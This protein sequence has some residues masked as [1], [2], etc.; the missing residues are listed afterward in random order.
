MTENGNGNGQGS[1]NPRTIFNWL[2]GLFIPLWE[3]VDLESGEQRDV[4]SQ[5]VRNELGEEDDSNN[6]RN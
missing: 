4:D 3:R 6:S 2:R 1:F 5:D